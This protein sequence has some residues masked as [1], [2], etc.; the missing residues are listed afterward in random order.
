MCRLSL[1][2]LSQ[3]LQGRYSRRNLRSTNSLLL[4]FPAIK[5]G[6]ALRDKAF[7]VA[8]PTLWNSVPKEP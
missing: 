8:A 2:Y 4:A 5:S 3:L 7:A 1:I 6:R